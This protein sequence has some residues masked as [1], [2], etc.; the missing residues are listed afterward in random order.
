MIYLDNGATTLKKPE[1]MIQAVI[2]A[3]QTMGNA[4]RGATEESLTTARIIYSA[5]ERLNQLFH[6]EGAKQIAFTMNSTEALNT[7]IKGLFKPGDHIITSVMEHNSVLRPLQELVDHGVEVTYIDTDEYGVLKLRDIE[8]AIQD[9]TKGLVLTHASNLT[10]NVNPIIELGKLA[11]LYDLLFIVDASQTAGALPINVQ[12]AHIDVLSFT[13]HKGLYGPQGTGGLY[14]RPGLKIRPLKS[15]GSGIQTFN[16]YHPIEMPTAL[17]AGT[18]NGHGIAGLNAAVGFVL[19]YS[20]EKIA[21]EEREL[22]DYFVRQVSAIPG[23]KLYGQFEVGVDH[24]PVVAINLGDVDSSEVA[25]DLIED[26]EIEIR[27]G[28]H[29]APKMHQALHTERQGIVRFSFS[30]FTTKDELDVAIHALTELSR[31]YEL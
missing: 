1:V 12:A 2:A 15:G 24:A 25:S 27:S 29:C 17:E 28:G 10:G 19:E 26:Y 16:A 31:R 11:Q 8:P 9:N 4:G 3:L 22:T 13:G 18:M 14:V 6:G 23:I 5:R 21:R 30:H 7:A 20:V